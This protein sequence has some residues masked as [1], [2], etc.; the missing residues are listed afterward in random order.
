MGCGASSPAP[1]V[2]PSVSPVGTYGNIS[3]G[4]PAL[5][6][7]EDLDHYGLSWHQQDVS[8][9][10]KPKRS[11]SKILREGSGPTK[12]GARHNPYLFAEF[13]HEFVAPKRK[14]AEEKVIAPCR[15]SCYRL[16]HTQAKMSRNRA[17]AVL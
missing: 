2:L 1:S 14:V 3:P 10:P 12:G 13:Q 4:I 17:Y 16:R 8:D 5:L 11:S 9:R 7:R 15:S 6:S